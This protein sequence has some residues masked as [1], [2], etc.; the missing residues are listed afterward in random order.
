MFPSYSLCCLAHLRNFI[1]SS[2]KVQNKTCDFVS[3]R[4]L[5]LS[6]FSQL[7]AEKNKKHQIYSLTTIKHDLRGP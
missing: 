2:S 7:K 4:R 6:I 3:R 1:P 5:F